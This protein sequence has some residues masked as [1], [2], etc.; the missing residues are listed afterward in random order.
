ML[1]GYTNVHNYDQEI[2]HWVLQFTQKTI[3]QKC[4]MTAWG[5]LE[6]SVGKMRAL[7][8]CTS[9]HDCERHRARLSLRATKRLTGSLRHDYV[10]HHILR[11]LDTYKL[12]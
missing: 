11:I 8:L 7:G 12:Q 5:R 2:L 1:C 3:K 9:T 6:D 4:N 10:S